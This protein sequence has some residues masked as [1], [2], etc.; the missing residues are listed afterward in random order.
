ML[1]RIFLLFI[2]ALL[3]TMN[4]T[5]L[6]DEIINGG[7][8]AGTGVDADDWQEIATAANGTVIRDESEASSGNASA[9]MSFD[10]A[11]SATGANYFIQ[12]VGAL[13]SIDE[14]LNYDL[15]FDA[16]ADSTD[17]T[18]I[19]FFVQLQF[20]DLDGSDGGGVKGDT[21]LSMITDGAS[22]GNTISTNY[23]TFSLLD[24]DAPDGA[25]AYQ[26]SFQLPAGAIADIAN[27]LHVDNV[28]LTAVPEPASALIAGMA[29][30][31]FTLRRRKS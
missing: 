14:S 9:Y 26:V 28:S 8:E 7:F 18:G 12:Q 4:G 2:G 13:G 22:L 5:M 10:N 16:R 29:I 21:L 1:K 20:L 30:L 17:F 11:G 3:A 31:G 27:G 23:Q 6:A 15:V 24:V 19:Q 25:D